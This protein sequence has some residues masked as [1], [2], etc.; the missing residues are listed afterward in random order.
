MGETPGSQAKVVCVQLMQE[1]RLL[2]EIMYC[3]VASIMIQLVLAVCGGG[4][5]N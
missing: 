4:I 5:D 2:V 3:T 1:L